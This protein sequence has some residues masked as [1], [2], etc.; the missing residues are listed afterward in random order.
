MAASDIGQIV[1][2]IATAL[3]AGAGGYLGSY[4]RQKGKNLATREDLAPI[5]R[6]QET[7]RRE[8]S[9]IGFTHQRG[10]ELTREVLWDIQKKLAEMAWAAQELSAL[11]QSG[12]FPERRQIEFDRLLQAVRQ[13]IYL[14]AIAGS[15]IE[16]V[17]AANDL[18]TALRAATVNLPRGFELPAAQYSALQSR[19]DTAVMTTQSITRRILF[20]TDQT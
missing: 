1:Q 10:W 17:Q 14:R 15:L 20:P 4:L 6:T 11:S 13:L 16:N 12:A 8:I 18:D 5:V 19:I 9:H 7:I 3:V 2:L